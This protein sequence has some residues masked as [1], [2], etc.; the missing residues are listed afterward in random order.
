MP[1]AGFYNDN[2]YRAYPFVYKTTAPATPLPDACI[3]DCGIIMGLDSQFEPGVHNVWLAGVARTATDITFTLAT[4]APG[5]VGNLVFTRQLDAVE[6]LTEHV[7]GAQSTAACAEEPTWEGFLVTGVFA[8]LLDV[9]PEDSDIT[10]A[11]TDYILE[12][13]R[14][15][16]LVKSYL[17]SVSVGNYSRVI[18]SPPE[19]CGGSEAPEARTVIPHRECM[20][21]DLRFLAGYNCDISQVDRRNELV[22]AA[23]R[24]AGDNGDA[25]C[26]E[27]PLFDGEAPPEGSKLLSGGP[28]CDEIGFTINGLNDNGA[29][30]IIGGPG[31]NV[32]AD[33]EDPHGI[34]IERVSNVL[35]AD[36]G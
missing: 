30:R 22:V 15:Q 11:D 34:L 31:I 9:L 18:A 20:K 12:P 5:V 32:I 28:A 19:E 8:D 2:E 7:E 29:V 25:A 1:R 27:I 3:V 13:S 16:S 36:C 6:W 23:V 17:R 24:G 21:G 14:I 33:P 35:T 26:E 4:D 10:F